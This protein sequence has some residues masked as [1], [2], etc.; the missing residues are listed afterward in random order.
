MTS[1]P[2]ALALILRFSLSFVSRN[3]A[4]SLPLVVH[5]QLQVT[6]SLGL[7]C[8]RPSGSRPVVIRSIAP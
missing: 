5:E 2:E 7:H 4:R 6:K 1:S 3:D 8:L